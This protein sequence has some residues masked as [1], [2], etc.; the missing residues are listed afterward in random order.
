M[1]S[2]ECQSINLSELCQCIHWARTN[3][4]QQ[5][6]L[7]IHHPRC[8]HFNDSLMDVWKVEVDGCGCYYH[9]TEEGAKMSLENDIEHEGSGRIEKVKMHREVFEGLPEFEGF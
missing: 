3:E 9:E 8:E 1:N 5:L 6:G 7:T 4:G 2:N